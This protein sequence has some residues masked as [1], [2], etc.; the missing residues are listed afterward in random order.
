[1]AEVIDG[2]ATHVHAHLT[3]LG[4][5]ERFFGTRQ[6]VVDLQHGAYRLYLSFPWRLRK[7]AAEGKYLRR[8]PPGRIPIPPI[9]IPISA[10]GHNP[11]GAD[12]PEPASR[13]RIPSTISRGFV[14]DVEPKLNR[15]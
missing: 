14:P 6:R 8:V 3:S 9:S 10:S 15:G 1:M 5:L 4:R 2:H 7:V 11:T 13:A 12:R